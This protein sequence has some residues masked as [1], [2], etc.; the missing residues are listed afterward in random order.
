[1]PT[2]FN[3]PFAGVDVWFPQPTKDVTQFSPMLVAFGRLTPGS[4][5]ARASAELQ[6][7]N[8]QYATA[9]PGMLDTKPSKPERVALLKET[10]V[11]NVRGVLW[12]L[13]GAV[14]FVLL[15]ACGNVAG[16]LLARATSRSR[17][18]A[19][20]AALGA[21]GFRVITQVLIESITLYLVAAVLGTALAWWMVHVVSLTGSIGELPRIGEIHL[22]ATA[23]AFALVVA[24][25]TGI[26][27]GL[28]PSLTASRP[29]LAAV[30]KSRGELAPGAHKSHR[31]NPRNVLVVGQVAL[32][33]VL[34]SGTALLVR[35]LVHLNQVDM[36]FDSKD[37]L[38]FRI[39]LSPAHYSK[40]ESQVAFYDEVLRR[41]DSLPGVQSSTV[42][43]TLP[44]TG[45]ARMPVQPADEP[46]RKLNERPLGIIQFIT[47]D[48]FRTLRVPLR[49]GREFSLHDKT[50]EPPVTIINEALARKLWPD[51]PQFNP[52]G[53][54]ILMGARTTQYEIVGVVGDIR[55]RLDGDPMPSMYWSAYQVMS[56]T[57]MLAVR[58]ADDS[59]RY[60]EQMRRV[61][62]SVD[63]AQP[64]SAVHTM[65]EL[66][67]QEQG[68][69]RLV[70]LVLGAFASVAVL[71]TMVGIYG[72]ITY[73]VVQRTAELGIRRALGA[74]NGNILWLVV[75]RG[76]GLTASGL[77][78]GIAGALALTRFTQ[79]LL[80]RVSPHD[81]ATFVA[82]ALGTA[83][84]SLVGSYLP[85]RRAVR[86]DPMQALRTE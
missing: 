79:S 27:F 1:M 81:P 2:D 60:A 47:P 20:R 10:L 54:H 39:S 24:A 52:I 11:S 66:A 6:V 28:F 70:L 59:L 75:G 61:V 16:L 32:S 12:M 17:E 58:T 5:L 62:I 30:L 51:Y 19:V 72:T 85:A 82:V 43:L 40:M 86:V 13:F 23:L 69:R 57:M 78:I 34:L 31:A 67:E 42:S 44:M 71:L 38:T 14:S 49:R 80:F 48:Y 25:L 64:I 55:Q 35:S 21:Q 18:F 84:L 7:I 77:V 83:A 36:G 65:T 37:L 41:I 73:W 74:T 46:L 63:S 9:H 50:G 3:F 56:P 45:F 8:R 29:D 76:L 26:A 68:P 22:D 33:I 53:R 4:T 15:I